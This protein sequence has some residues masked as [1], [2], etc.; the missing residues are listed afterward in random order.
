M[1]RRTRQL[2]IAAL[3]AILLFP[4]R[5]GAEE[6]PE[7]ATL[8]PRRAEVTAPVG[9]LARLEL[10][11]AVV[12]A[13]R[14]D[15][16]DLR[17][18]DA[19]GREVPYLVLE[20]MAA[21]EAVEV[22]E[23][24]R[25]ELLEVARRTEG[26]EPGPD[27]QHETYELSPPPTLSPGERWDLVLAT[28]RREL[29]RRV[30]VSLAGG[31]PVARRLWA[32][33]VFRLTS[34]DRERLRVPL[35]PL[36]APGGANR[37][38]VTLEGED[39]SFLE[40]A[41]RYERVREIPGAGRARVPLV[42]LNRRT[43][44]D[45]TV[46]E[47]A[48]PRGLVPDRLVL[49]TA[50]PVLERPVEVW[51]EG[52]GA[53]AEP[54]A[55]ET[56]VRVPGPDPLEHLDVALAPPRGDRLRLVVVDGDSPPLDELRVVA[57]VRRPALLF[58][59]P[60]SGGEGTSATATLYF[61]G[62]RAHRPHYDLAELAPALPAAG[63]EA[64][65][66]ERLYDPAASVA[67]EIAPPEANPRFDPTP[68]LAFA[69]H[70]AAHLDPGPWRWR[71]PLEAH[72]SPE[73]LVRLELGL[74]E[75]ARARED[76]ADLRVV[77]GEERQWAYLLEPGSPERHPL[78]VQGPETDDGV[79]TYRIVLP[80]S[81]AT[82][83]G[84]T[85]EVAAP[86][87]DRPFTLRATRGDAETLLAHGRLV[88]PPRDPRP[89]EV[90]FRATRIDSLTLEVEDGS[91]APLDVTAAT[92]WFLGPDLYFAAPA[93]DYALLV[94]NL[95]ADAPRYELARVRE[96]VLAVSAGRAD[97][98]PVEENPA[99]RAGARWL[100]GSGAQKLLLWS[101]LILAVAGL[102][103]LTLRLARREEA[104]P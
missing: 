35:P 25:P 73:G 70:P 23:V 9:R 46:I 1:R 12:G 98:A 21:G 57:A 60:G 83:E 68:A 84:L 75:L 82:L 59:L 37:L 67:A 22:R 53:A 10:P 64:R 51:D 102:G 55:R 81:P 33:S 38:V 56:V 20:A 30:E 78:T 54:L 45:R 91:D 95:D 15:L 17:I 24:V 5:A 2:A 32:G 65:I 74:E 100:R 87:F 4:G 3:G 58:A 6:A 26:R 7:L 42:V 92:G 52:P 43:R 62:G 31:A 97:A 14:S 50:T 76:R 79:S 66:A 39:G 63:S 77:D 36:P 40:P 88:L 41:F 96:V 61:G 69:M 89:V 29:V 28:G 72:P 44:E 104:E 49:E 94:G 11:A 99:Y 93:G 34:P 101:A 86:Y 85:L 90:R 27:L 71:R 16:A 18:V 80:A 47:L 19:G 48:R 13:C 8:F 103:I